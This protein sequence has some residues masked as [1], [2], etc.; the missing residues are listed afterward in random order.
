MN[1]LTLKKQSL[2]IVTLIAAVV[3]FASCSKDKDN[4]PDQQSGYPKE[5]TVEYKVTS[6]NLPKA[7]LTFT[8]E[9][10]GTTRVSNAALPASKS[11]KRTVKFGDDASMGITSYTGGTIKVEIWIDG[12]LSK[13]E[14][15]SG[16]DVVSGS[17]SHVFM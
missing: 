2:K 5:V 16:T 12:K 11:F 6:T 10:G 9:T 8:N 13:T 7:D 3:F 1:L 15:Y 4:G 14:T 17:L